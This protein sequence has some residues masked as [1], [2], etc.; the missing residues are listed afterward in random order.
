MSARSQRRRRDRRHPR[1]CGNAGG[2]VVWARVDRT[3]SYRSSMPAGRLLGPGVEAECTGLTFAKSVH[4]PGRVEVSLEGGGPQEP[5]P[6]LQ[7]AMDEVFDRMD[8]PEAMRPTAT[9][10]VR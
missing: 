3:D 9:R 2:Q 8:L 6:V 10:R 4:N 7:A 5:D 1:V